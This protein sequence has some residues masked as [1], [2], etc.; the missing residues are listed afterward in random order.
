MSL[1]STAILSK[2]FLLIRKFKPYHIVLVCEK[3]DQP[4]LRFEKQTR[5]QKEKVEFKFQQIFEHKEKESF[6]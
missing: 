6:W 5:K 1:V 2:N 3:I 4:V